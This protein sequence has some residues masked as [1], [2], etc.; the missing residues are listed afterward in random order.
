MK[1]ILIAL[2]CL[3]VMTISA[4]AADEVC[5]NSFKFFYAEVMY[6]LKFESDNPELPCTSGLA[7]LYW[8]ESK[9]DGAFSVNS[10]GIVK[11]DGIGNFVLD[12]SMLYFL[13]S[14]T[15]IFEAY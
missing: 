3:A 2:M 4:Q 6:L 1:K 5:G 7:T 11:V 8:Q 12:G 10:K 14:T 9:M 13:N 15:I